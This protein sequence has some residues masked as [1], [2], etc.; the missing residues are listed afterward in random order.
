LYFVAE[1]IDGDCLQDMTAA[2]LYRMGW[3]WVQP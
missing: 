1:E 2:V 3:K